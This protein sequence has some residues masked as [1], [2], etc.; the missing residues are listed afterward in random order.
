MKTK[1]YSKFMFPFYWDCLV[2]LFSGCYFAIK[3]EC[4]CA[5]RFLVL[6]WESFS[7]LINVINFTSPCIFVTSSELFSTCLP[8]VVNTQS[9]LWDSGKC[10]MV[11]LSNFKNTR[12]ETIWLWVT[13]VDSCNTLFFVFRHFNCGWY[14]NCIRNNGWII[15]PRIGIFVQEMVSFFGRST[16]SCW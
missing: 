15:S 9:C 14:W 10:Q 11:L 2:F 1:G 16:K 7:K 5:K 6:L 4:L 8:V 13:I 12:Y 3:I